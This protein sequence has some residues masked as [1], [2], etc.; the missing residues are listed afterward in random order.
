MLPPLQPK[1]PDTA[2]LQYGLTRNP[3][4]LSATSH[5]WWNRKIC[6]HRPVGAVLR[7]VASS[8][9]KT[10]GQ[11][12]PKTDG[13]MNFAPC[14]HLATRKGILCARSRASS[15]LVRHPSSDH[16]LGA[17]ALPRCINN[18]WLSYNSPVGAI[19]RERLNALKIYFQRDKLC[20]VWYNSHRASQ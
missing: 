12:N 17:T 13:K 18:Y 7:Q 16:P 20:K 10:D 8:H 14:A 5:L 4:Y 2:E 19:S 15:H 9:P 1:H 6:R 11:T 3:A